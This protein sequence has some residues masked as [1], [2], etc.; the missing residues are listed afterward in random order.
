MSAT[1]AKEDLTDDEREEVAEA[2]KRKPQL[3]C[4]HRQ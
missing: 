4:R 2:P 3:C 1:A